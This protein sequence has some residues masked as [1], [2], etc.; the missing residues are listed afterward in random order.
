MSF[1]NTYVRRRSAKKYND[2]EWWDKNYYIGEI[3]DSHTISP[4]KSDLS[5]R[6]HYSSVELMIL[7]HL[8]NSGTDLS[9][10]RVLDIGSGAGHWIEFYKSLGAKTITGLDVSR[11][12]VNF[13]ESRFKADENITIHHGKASEI[14][15]KLSG[16]FDLINAIGVMFHIV[17]DSD[18]ARTVKLIGQS[19]RQNGLFVASG[20]FGLLDGL[21]A[22]IDEHGKF[23]K[24]LR[25][26]RNWKRCLEKSEFSRVY[27][28]KN[29]A[30]AKID[31]Y[32]PENN[33]LI[34]SK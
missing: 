27:F 23:N 15:E 7:R 16:E 12:C 34:A 13:L 22:Q 33:V 17:D 32:Q 28:Y 26:Y 9:G 25:S 5:T 11:S 2:R 10:S 18:W 31:D 1:V 20:H 4:G 14:L 24:R 19:L 30:N 21:N 6:H 29:S 8:Y 3:S